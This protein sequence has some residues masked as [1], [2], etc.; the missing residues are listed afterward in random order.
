MGTLI[1]CVTDIG[2]KLYK[3]QKLETHTNTH[4]PKENGDDDIKMQ[5]LTAE[6]PCGISH[7]PT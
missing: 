4:L 1:H 3:I 7:S 6:R 2:Y 5:L